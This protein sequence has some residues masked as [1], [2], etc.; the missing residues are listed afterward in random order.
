MSNAPATLQ[1]LHRQASA[2][3]QLLTLSEVCGLL[4]KSR[5]GLYKLMAADKSFPK[6]IKDSQTR[7]ARAYF[8][9]AEIVAWQQSKLA[10]R[11]AV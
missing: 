3:A 6:P 11:N 10:A 1:D 9:A 4:R 8:A 5:S 2:L 7:S